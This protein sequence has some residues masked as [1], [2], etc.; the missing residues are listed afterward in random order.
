MATPR[1]VLPAAARQRQR[2]H[3]LRAGQ[4]G[5]VGKGQH[6]SARGAGRDG[7]AGKGQRDGASGSGK[8]G[9]AGKGG[10][11]GKGTG[12]GGK[13]GRHQ[14]HGGRGDARDERRGGRGGV[15]HGSGM[16]DAHGC[17]HGGACSNSAACSGG[18][19]GPIA[20]G[21]R[22]RGRL[23]GALHDAS[24]SEQGSSSSLIVAATAPAVRSAAAAPGRLRRPATEWAGLAS[25]LGPRDAAPRADGALSPDALGRNAAL[26]ADE[27]LALSSIY[28]DEMR[29]PE[30]GD[31]RVVD[32]S[33][34]LEI[35]PALAAA[36][37]IAAT[38]GL[39]GGGLGGG[40]EGGAA[41]A[42]ADPQADAGRLLPPLKLRVR[43]GEGYPSHGPP[44]LALR[45][46]WLADAQLASLAASLDALARES[47]AGEPAVC[48]WVEWLRQEGLAELGLAADGAS[49]S[50][51]EEEHGEEEEG[52]GEEGADLGD[53]ALGERR[54]Q[55]WPRKRA[56]VLAL[57]R[58]H[59]AAAAERAWA[60]AVHTC[61]VCLDQRASL[62]CLRLVRCGHTFCRGC[63]RGYWS[64]QMGAG[65]ARALLCPAP[66]C[67]LAASPPEVQTLLPAAEYQAYERL[68]LESTLAE[69]ED[70]VWCPRCEYPAELEA[71]EAGRPRRLAICAHCANSFCV[72]CRHTHLPYPTLPTYPTLPYPTYP[73]LPYPTLTLPIYPTLRRQ[74]W[75]G[76]A[77]CANLAAR[78]RA[79]DARGREALTQKYGERLMEEIESAEWIRSNAQPCP[80]C[81]GPTE[82]AGGC[83]HITCV[84]CRH[85]WCWLCRATYQQGHFRTGGCEQ[86]SQD[87][88]DEIHISREEFDAQYVILNH[89]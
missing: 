54:A 86:F 49:L 16:E 11:A 30:G 70:V 24:K 5:R 2:E 8:D 40:G 14:S 21:G 6:H 35:P 36:A 50:L 13:G 51:P 85:E 18:A 58:S 64:S 34:A 44:E 61:G 57:L 39:G 66:T 9:P 74:A 29:E 55:R 26:Q 31:G 78:W 81:H 42:G 20:G 47:A 10:S 59:A 79:A 1:D 88:F 7:P 4:D 27:R 12:R 53:A 22:G 46:C 32:I 17:I 69:M 23:L 33:I 84:T 3:A 68:L 48:N 77:P 63:L 72:E 80:K 60:A 67:R 25:L 52:H 73:T 38:G 89:W 19:G 87:F 56:S 37:A 75:H 41:A 83:N 43:F 71:A 28:S 62:D 76:L 15:G 82:K 65:L 45:C